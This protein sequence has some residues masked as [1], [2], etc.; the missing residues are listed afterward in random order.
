M[1]LRELKKQIANNTPNN[2]HKNTK[3]QPEHKSMSMHQL[4]DNTGTIIFCWELSFSERL[5]ILFSGVLWHQV[6]TFN[7]TLQPQFLTAKKPYIDTLTTQ[8]K[9]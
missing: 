7:R 9:T 1:K 3:G 2:T 6:L 4:E 5:K 8:E